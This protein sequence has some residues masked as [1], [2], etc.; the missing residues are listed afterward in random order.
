MTP[1]NTSSEVQLL[2]VSNVSVVEFLRVEHKRSEHVY[3]AA[4]PKLLNGF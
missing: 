3:Q 1:Q 4:H 2:C